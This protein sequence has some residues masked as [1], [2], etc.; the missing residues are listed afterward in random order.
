[1]MPAMP[2]VDPLFAPELA[3]QADFGPVWPLLCCQAGDAGVRG[4]HPISCGANAAMRIRLCANTNKPTTPRTLAK[5]RTGMRAAGH[6]PPFKAM[7]LGGEASLTLSAEARLRYDIY[8]NA[9]L[10]G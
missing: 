7:P 10:R 5:P 2:V 9:Q 4:P 1:M 3:W 6:A 8:N